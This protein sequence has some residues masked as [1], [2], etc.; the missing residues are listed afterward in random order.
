MRNT[1][2]NF[3]LLSLLLCFS[4]S[5]ASYGQRS[6]AK[7]PLIR[8]IVNVTPENATK[9]APLAP[10]AQRR[11]DAFMTVWQ[12]VNVNYF[13]KTFSGLDWNKIR[14]EYQPRV[15]AAKTDAEVHRLLAEMVNR[16]GTSHF[17]IIP[18]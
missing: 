1:L 6:R 3:S 9:P 15:T 12:T 4:L 8:A 11:Q 14:E 17:A 16:L 10:D 7:H 13:D 18:P 5:T 2:F